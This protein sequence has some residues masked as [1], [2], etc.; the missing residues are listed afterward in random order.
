MR[1]FAYRSA[2]LGVCPR[3][4]VALHCQACQLGLLCMVTRMFIYPW[5]LFVWVSD[6]TLK[7]FDG[8]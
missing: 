5:H 1:E 3:G 6:L 8:R 7:K 4:P 2:S